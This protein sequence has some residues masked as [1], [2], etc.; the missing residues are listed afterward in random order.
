MS[1]LYA[2][3]ITAWE[4][5]LASRDRNRTVQE[6]DWGLEWL[7]GHADP[8]GSA[9]DVCSLATAAAERSDEFYGYR[10][11]T[12]FKLEANQ[13]TFTSAVTS[14]YPENNT[15]HARYFPAERARGRAVVVMP[16]W[17]ADETSH[18]SLCRLMNRFGLSAVRLNKAYHGPR[19]PSGM[20]R[21]DHHVSSNIGRTIHAMRQSVVDARSCVDWLESRG[22]RSLGIA[23]TSLG[24]CVAFIVAAH[25]SRLRA[26]VFN[27]VSTYFADA[28]WTGISTRHVRAALEG[29][30]DLAEL[31]RCWAVISPAIYLGR[32]RG[33]QF[34]S[35]LIWG[36]YD[37]V[38]VPEL[39]RDVLEAYRKHGLPH[40]ELAMPCGHYTIGQFPF[41]WI[42]GISICRFLG[43]RL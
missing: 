8:A 22:Y 17:N 9:G 42:D 16:Q 20:A 23:G 34:H 38:F 5:K 12:D 1:S 15:V 14:P 35:L 32:L 28:V 30:I 21:A 33:R 26:G 31:R 7:N 4:L 11:P 29:N 41:N 40:E 27:H 25:D 43:R 19:R 2:R 18:V 10:T 3:W 36:R 6:F 37:P 24:S 39:S 13:L